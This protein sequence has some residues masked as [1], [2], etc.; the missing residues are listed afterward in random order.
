MNLAEWDKRNKRTQKNGKHEK[1]NLKSKDRAFFL[2]S[3]SRCSKL[4][5]NPNGISVSFDK[6]GN[7]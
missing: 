5:I 2:F 3:Y 6:V 1:D 7:V 4:P